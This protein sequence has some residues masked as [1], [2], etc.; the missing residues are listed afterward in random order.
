MKMK[1]NEK[2]EKKWVTKLKK[3]QIN[4]PADKKYNNQ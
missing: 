3:I 2:N 4:I 1:M